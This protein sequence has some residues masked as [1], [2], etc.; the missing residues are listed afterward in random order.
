MTENS[1]DWLTLDNAGKIFP[2]QNSKKWSNVFRMSVELK[3]DIEPELLKEALKKTLDRIPSF[4]VRLRK[5]LFADYFER[6]D[7]ECPVNPDV[8]NFCYRID[9]RENNG[10]PFRIF[11]HKSRISID[12]YHAL[13]DG[14]GA[15]VFLCTLAGEYLRLRGCETSHGKSVLNV[16]DSP[17]AEEYEDA[18][19]RYATSKES[20]K[21]LETPAYH[22]KGTP[23]PAYMSNFT[24]VLMSFSALHA[25]SKGYGVTVTE[26][27]AA[28][29]MDIHY[30]K[31][32]SEGKRKKDVTVQIPVNLRK[33]FPSASLRNFVICLSVK[34][35]PRKNEYTFEEIV[36]TV[37]E[38]LKAANNRS[39]L[40]AYIT[41]TV[42][43]QTKLLRFV[44]LFIK[45][46]AVKVS[47]SFG[48]EYS[49]SALLS[50]L[51]PVALPED[52]KEQVNSFSFFTGAGL[53]NGC[54]CGA[55]S[56]GDRL[57][58]T[59]SNRYEEGDTEREFIKRLTDMGIALTVETNRSDFLND[60]ENIPLG[61]RE[62]FSDRV[63]IPSPDDRTKAEK[64]PLSLK[65][66]IR[67]FFIS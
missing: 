53:V 44:P 37:S 3:Q 57:A 9:F 13:C 43:L 48:A 33:D 18:Y 63:F 24:T 52:M 10:Y 61:D 38:Q 64:A 56:V 34:I 32:L 22:K 15:S 1:F 66:K 31:Q 54:R 45:N 41:Q 6:N 40:H 59:F 25:L 8:K 20:C 14:Y 62:A 67:R 16:N 5:S 35:S 65:E 17:E 55:A 29:L 30:R 26:L 47:F 49:T 39:F 27:L 12:V 58:L 50:N 51:G 28:V 7:S 42:N 21:L 23:L 46:T 2:G 4:K 60:G 36:Q 11:Y 19:E